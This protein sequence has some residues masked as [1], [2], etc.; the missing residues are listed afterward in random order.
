MD[1]SQWCK[2][3]KWDSF[4]VVNPDN[5][6][7]FSDVKADN[8]TSFNDVNPDNGTSSSDITVKNE[9]SFND[10]GADSGTSFN[11]VKLITGPPS[12]M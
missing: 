5:G 7:L 6:T 8:R 9:A 4:N 2:G 1:L 10:V 3:W 12:M 11:D